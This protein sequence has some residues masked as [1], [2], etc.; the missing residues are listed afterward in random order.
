[1][2]PPPR[3]LPPAHGNPGRPRRGARRAAPFSGGGTERDR[4]DTERRDLATTRPTTGISSCSEDAALLPTRGGVV[5]SATAE[6]TV[7]QI[8]FGLFSTF[9]LLCSAKCW[10]TVSSRDGVAD[11]RG[12]MPQCRSRV[13]VRDEHR[14]SRICRAMYR[15]WSRRHRTVTEL[16][17]L[18][19]GY[20]SAATWRAL[21]SRTCTRLPKAAQNSSRTSTQESIVIAVGPCSPQEFHDSLQVS[22]EGQAASAVAQ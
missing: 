19:A 8:W 11:M 5:P 4:R 12:T 7:R 3:P 2:P 18:C 15:W 17:A 10:R 6:T 22:V 9:L 20:W 1:M 13:L 21:R 16:A 14:A